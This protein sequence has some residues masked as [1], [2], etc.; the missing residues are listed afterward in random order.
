MN[1]IKNAVAVAVVALLL[2]ATGAVAG[3][4]VTSAS[5]KDGTIQ[6]QDLRPSLLE[7]LSQPGPQGPVGPQ[8][9]QGP[10][11]EPG[12]PPAENEPTECQPPCWPQG[13]GCG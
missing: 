8:G 13:C 4:L 5:I 10:Q 6:R 11:G 9:P 1:T 12:T 3:S 7:R 2:T